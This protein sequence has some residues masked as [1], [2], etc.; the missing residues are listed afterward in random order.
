[1]ALNG[2]LAGLVAITAGCANVSPLSAIIMGALAGIVVVLSVEFIDKVL[3][4]DDPVGAGVTQIV[5]TATVTAC[6]PRQ[7]LVESVLLDQLC[8]MSGQVLL[9]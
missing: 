8:E 7:Y 6:D 4:I 2:A 5:N 1:M 3:H 9:Q